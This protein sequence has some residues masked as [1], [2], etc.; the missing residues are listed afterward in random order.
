MANLEQRKSQIKAHLTQTTE[1]NFFQQPARG[2]EAGL[3]Q[4]KQ[5]IQDH[6]RRTRG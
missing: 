1:V 3:D 6:V 2:P 4:R 5:R